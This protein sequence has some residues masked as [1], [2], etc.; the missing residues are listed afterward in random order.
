M[1]GFCEVENATQLQGVLLLAWRGITSINNPANIPGHSESDQTPKFLSASL[2][3][4]PN[5]TSVTAGP[6]FLI[7]EETYPVF[8]IEYLFSSNLTP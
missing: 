3:C 2:T 7:K 1:K 4:I 5:A 6:E 8:T